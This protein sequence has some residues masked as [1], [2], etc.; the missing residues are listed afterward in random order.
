[1]CVIMTNFTRIGKSIR[2]IWSYFHFSSFAA[3]HHT[4]S[5][6]I[7]NFNCHASSEPNMCQR[8]KF[9][10]NQSN[11]SEDM[12]YFR[13]FKMAAICHLGFQ[14]KLEILPAEQLQRA[15]VCHHAKFHANRSNF[16][17]DM[18]IFRFF[19]MAVVRHL[20]FL[21]LPNVNCQYSA[22]GQYVSPCQVSC[23]SVQ[24]FQRYRHFLFFKMAAVRHLGFLV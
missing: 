10:A 21:K 15:N 8:A 6:K 3:V 16:S 17:R 18:A 23:R 20:V 7:R 9:H 13:F 22:E 14:K 5:L 11:Q 24:P 2:E 19:K 12:A 4:G 1:M